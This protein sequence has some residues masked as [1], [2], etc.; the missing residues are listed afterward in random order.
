MSVHWSYIAD[1]FHDYLHIIFLGMLRVAA[2]NIYGRHYLH[3][4]L[5]RVSSCC[6]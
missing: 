2:F 4:I 6:E 3:I 1:L 5:D